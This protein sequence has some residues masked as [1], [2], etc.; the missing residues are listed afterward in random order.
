[1]DTDITGKA[2]QLKVYLHD[3][4]RRIQFLLWRMETSAD[5]RFLLV[6]R[7]RNLK[8]DVFYACLL[9]H[10]EQSKTVCDKSYRV[11]RP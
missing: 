1:M 11:D 2:G 8:S 6:R 9:D 3:T 7:W 10:I 4:I 5:V